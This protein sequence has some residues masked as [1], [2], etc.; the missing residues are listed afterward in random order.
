MSPYV[1]NEEL[2]RVGVGLFPDRAFFKSTD[3]IDIDALIKSGVFQFSKDIQQPVETVQDY[4]NV[5]SVSISTDSDNK[6][7]KELNEYLNYLELT[8]H[9]HSS[10]TAERMQTFITKTDHSPLF[11]IAFG[12]QTFN[13]GSL[14]EIATTEL[15]FNKKVSR[16]SYHDYICIVQADGDNMGKVVTHLPENTI[17]QISEKLMKFGKEVCELIT[18]FGGLP[19]YA[20]GDDLLFIAPVCGNQSNSIFHLISSIDHA[21]RNIANEVSKLNIKDVQ[22]VNTFERTQFL[23]YFGKKE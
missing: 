18:D 12:N 19:I 13:I 5:M 7:I 14:E 2:G 21:Y 22:G 8:N 11:E 20:G 4:F 23:K 16:K 9:A 1:P 3:D 6:A 15:N 17:Y 10:Q